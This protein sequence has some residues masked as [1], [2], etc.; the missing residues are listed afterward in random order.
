MNKIITIS[1]KFGSSRNDILKDFQSFYIFYYTDLKYWIKRCRNRR[2]KQ[3]YFSYKD[4]QHKRFS[5]DKNRHSYYEFYTVNKCRDNQNYNI[6]INT[7]RKDIKE[8]T[9]FLYRYRE[10]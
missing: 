5:I 7:S 2:I 10:G 3:K 9:C 1:Q 4:V 6:N 8:N